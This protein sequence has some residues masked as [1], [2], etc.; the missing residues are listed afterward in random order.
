MTRLARA[1]FAA[2]LLLA[3][4]LVSA[5]DS[6]TADP[7]GAERAPLTAA[8]AAGVRTAAALELPAADAL[9]LPATSLA[10]PMAASPPVAATT[11]SSEPSRTP[12]WATTLAVA[13]P[14]A[15]GLSTVHA[16]KQ[17]GPKARV[18]EGNTF[19]HKLFGADVKA[20]EIMAFKTAQAALMGLAV[21]YGGQTSRERAIG[22]ALVQGALHTVV[23]V[24]NM[25]AA[26]TARRLNAGQKP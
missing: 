11:T 7:P 3:P 1:V 8:I 17:S 13:G 6:L 16:I 22:A 9:V 4:S 14:L 5:Q 12:W 25:R 20:G 18:M 19:Y 2:A 21:H 15:D 26:A 10:S 24:L 23:S